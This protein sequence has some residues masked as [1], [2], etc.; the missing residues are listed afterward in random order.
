MNRYSLRP[1]L[2]W[3]LMAAAIVGVIYLG[4]QQNNQSS[5][6]RLATGE[7]GSYAMAVG[8][9]LKKRIEQASDYKVE[10]VVSGDSSFNR[11][12]VQSG[13]ADMA[14]VA[15]ANTEM[16]NLAVV[17]PIVRQYL[18][19]LVNADGRLDNI[20]DLPGHRISLGSLESDQRKQALRLLGYYSIEER[21]LRATELPY[22]ELMTG[23]E[24]DG[25]I[26]SA[27]LQDPVLREMMATGRFKLLPIMAADAFASVTPHTKAD[28]L[29]L[30]SYPSVNGP[31][32]VDWMPSVYSDSVLVT[33]ADAP[34]AMVDTVLAVLMSNK[35]KADYPL[36]TEWADEKAGRFTALDAHP[37][38]ARYFDPYGELKT[39]IYAGLL[40]LWQ[41]KFW[42]ICLL[43]LA[44]TANARWQQFRLNRIEL[45]KLQRHKRI[46]K[47]LEDINEL[48]IM[49]ADSK[50]YRVLNR[51]LA[52]ARKIKQD[53]LKV[54][55][56]LAM[57]DSQIFVAFL[58]QC[59]HVIGDVQW[60]L[61]MG[62]NSHTMMVS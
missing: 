26:V 1:W 7:R 16:V 54:A 15:P 51:R 60:K 45:D 14:I 35:T 18:Q 17:A 34:S 21:S 57:T 47:M 32:P 41:Y 56:E 22:Q 44:L 9:D 2:S 43:V 20:Q 11:G 30:G 50:D 10:L 19:V 52:D 42:I 27:S 53:G 36:L 12:L 25:A 31:M 40:Q 62:M 3:G 48:E 61:S 58:Q 13:Q 29:P 37:A 6:L 28:M 39:T 4:Y 49:Q 59:D 38:V 46:E 8:A 24:L 5:V 33:R 23:R 55:T